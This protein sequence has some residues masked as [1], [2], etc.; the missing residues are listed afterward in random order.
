MT[1]HLFPGSQPHLYQ[2]RDRRGYIPKYC[3]TRG[4]TVSGLGQGGHNANTGLTV[5]PVYAEYRVVWSSR[6]AWCTVGIEMQGIQ[7]GA[8]NRNRW[9]YLFFVCLYRSASP[10]PH[11]RRWFEHRRVDIPIAEF[12]PSR[13]EFPQLMS[14]HFL[15]YLNR[16]EILPVVY[17]K[18]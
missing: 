14:N 2:L 9:C 12:W 16:Q 4:Y 13:R 3:S 10:H 18:L 15:H 5:S 6:D 8:T 7:V 11:L 1:P 17:H